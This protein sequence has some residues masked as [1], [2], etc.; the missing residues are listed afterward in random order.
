MAYRS[1]N[2]SDALPGPDAL[3]MSNI[4]LLALNWLLNLGYSSM[5]IM[6]DPARILEW[7]AISFSR[8]I[9]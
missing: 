6:F 1:K 2:S 4:H 5:E 7:A 3:N 8:G 9:V